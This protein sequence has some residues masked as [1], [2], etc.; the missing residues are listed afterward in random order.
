MRFSAEHAIGRKN[1]GYYDL[2]TGNTVKQLAAG[3]K[4]ITSPGLLGTVRFG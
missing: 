1:Q 3:L 2:Y 4:A